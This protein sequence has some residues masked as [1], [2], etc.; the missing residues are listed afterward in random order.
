[1]SEFYVRVVEIEKVINHPN[2]DRLDI[3]TVL[4]DY[5]VIAKRDEYRVGDKAVYLSVDTLVPLNDERW[6]FLVNPNKSKKE[7]ERIKAK[8]LRGVFS[9]GILTPSYSSWEVG[10]DVQELLGI[11]KWEPE[12]ER[13]STGGLSVVGP[14]VPI[15]DLEGLRKYKSVLTQGEEIILTEKIHGANS[16]YLLDK[17][18]K[19]WAG[20]HRQFKKEDPNNMWWKIVEKY[21]LKEKLAKYPGYAFYGEVYGNVQK[22]FPYDNEKGEVSFRLFDIWLGHTWMDYDEVVKI[23]SELSLD[24]VPQLYRGPWSEDLLNL[25]E[26]N[27]TL[28]NHVREGFVLQTAKERW[29]ERAGRL[30]LKMVGCDYLLRE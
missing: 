4:G 16:R 30:K 7:Y 3:C 21:N 18:G 14:N 1:M 15:Y 23:A 11:K 10:Q 28:G 27:S 19:F 29:H 17:D 8:R 13:E 24:M 25:A 26:G 9:M 6:Q 2:A 22:D 20:S 5:P 12:V